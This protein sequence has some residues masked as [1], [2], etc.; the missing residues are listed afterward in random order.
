MAY[1]SARFAKGL[2]DRCGFEYKLL[3]LKKEW[4]NLK[5]CTQ[6]FETKHP[7][8][9]PKPVVADPEALYQPRPNNDVEVG[10]GYVLSN[11]DKIL[12]SSIEGFTMTSSLGEVTIN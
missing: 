1:A 5:T 12:G 4:N 9:E 3:E 7:Q 6:C 2:C 11:N 10:F 8:L